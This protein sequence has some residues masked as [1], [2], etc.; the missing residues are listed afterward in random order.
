MGGFNHHAE[1]TGG[2]EIAGRT[3]SVSGS[4]DALAKFRGG[5]HL[6]L[7]HKQLESGNAKNGRQGVA[8]D[9]GL[10]AGLVEFAFKGLESL[11]VI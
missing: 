2:P 8:S 5:G 6:F 3:L 9:F 1:S 11:P 7:R 4:R 10:D